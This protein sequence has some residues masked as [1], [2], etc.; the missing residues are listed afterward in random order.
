MNSRLAGAHKLYVDANIIIY[1]VE[2]DEAHQ[3][4]ADALFEYAEKRH[5]PDNQRNRGW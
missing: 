3:K 5:R 2:G 4:M 1:F